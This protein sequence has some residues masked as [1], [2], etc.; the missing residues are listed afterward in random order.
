[1]QQFVKERERNQ[2]LCNSEPLPEE[3]A[4]TPSSAPKALPTCKASSTPRPKTT[5]GTPKAKA[6]DTQRG[7]PDFVAKGKKRSVGGRGKKTLVPEQQALAALI[8][9][10]KREQRT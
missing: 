2:L 4:G 7:D 1:M 6:K 10:I 8:T 9:P 5:K 3:N